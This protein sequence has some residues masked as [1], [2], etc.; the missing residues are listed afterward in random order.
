[1]EP[2]ETRTR[3]VIFIIAVLSTAALGYLALGGMHWI[4][5]YVSSFDLSKPHPVLR[6]AGAIG[7]GLIVILRFYLRRRAKLARS[8]K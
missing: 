6:I 4:F 5:A 1:M 2:L 7:I 8:R 3:I